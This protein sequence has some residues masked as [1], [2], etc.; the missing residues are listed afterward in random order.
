MR[1]FRYFPKTLDGQ[2]NILTNLSKKIL[3]GKNLSEQAVIYY[4]YYIKDGERL[5]VLSKR[6]YGNE[7][8]HW[9]IMLINNMMD[10]RQDLPLTNRE[11][12]QYLS[13]LYGS[14]ETALTTVH[15]LED[16]N[17]EIVDA[18]HPFSKREV[19]VYEFEERKNEE[20]RLIKL[21]RPEYISAFVEEL[22]R[23]MSSE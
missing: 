9:I 6:L 22:K 7:E 12:E 21:V 3:L 18:Q 19:S 11:F 1:F 15:H 2:G 16:E 13:Y 10:P 20:K 14:V 17:G 5:D 4:T 23:V 8:Y